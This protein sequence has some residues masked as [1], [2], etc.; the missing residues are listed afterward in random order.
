MYPV[1]K[2]SFRRLRF[3]IN[4]MLFRRSTI[5]C[6]SFRLEFV[7]TTGRFACKED[8][9]ANWPLSFLHHMS[10]LH[11][12][13]FSFSSFTS[14][15]PVPF[16]S[17]PPAR[18]PELR[19]KL[20]EALVNATRNCGDMVPRFSQHLLPALLTGVKDPEPLIRASSLSN[21]GEVCQLLRF[22][23]G[24]VVHEV[25]NNNK[26]FGF[27]TFWFGWCQVWGTGL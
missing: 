9:Q 13:N 12:T 17:R 26:R 23:L 20:G 5:G 25:S 22:S 27:F 1:I 6:L 16:R 7:S 24:T 15:I 18:S 11:S 8:V 10:V 3:V 21:L 19:M 4:V 14:F 2:V